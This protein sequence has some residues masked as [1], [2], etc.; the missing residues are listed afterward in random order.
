MGILGILVSY[1]IILLN[2]LY[3]EVIKLRSNM[4]QRNVKMKKLC[5]KTLK[6]LL[7]N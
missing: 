3:L 1:L 5:S 2:E 4:K 6:T 7:M